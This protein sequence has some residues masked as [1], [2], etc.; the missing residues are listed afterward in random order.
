[1]TKSYSVHPRYIQEVNLAWRLKSDGRSQEL[2]NE[3][4]RSLSLVIV[5]LFL[6]GEPVN[7]LN[8]IEICKILGLNWRQIAGLDAQENQLLLPSA[9]VKLSE[10]NGV[11]VPRTAIALYQP[12]EAVSAI[13]EAI[14]ALVSTLCEMLRRLTRKA[15]DLLN[16]DRTSIFLLDREKNELGSLIADDGEGGCLV[17][18]IPAN[19]GIASLAATTLKVIN[20]PFDV[21]DD[22]RSQEAKKIDNKTGYRTYSI[23]AWPLLNEQKNLVAVVQLIN[24]LKPNHNPEDDLSKRIDNN[25]FT[26]EDEARFAKFAPSILHI[27]ERCQFCYQLSLKLRQNSGLDPKGVILWNTELIMELKRQEQHLRKSLEKI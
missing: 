24:K 17:I 26:P 4:G 25:G 5:N 2:T 1:M 13:E 22:P 27:L 11:T 8:F 15:G 10:V 7:R 12:D 20:V 14:N 21:Y 9:R 16:A 18:D 23:L 19:R 3:L 6:K